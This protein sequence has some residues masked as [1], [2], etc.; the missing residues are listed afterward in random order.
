MPNRIF[1][2]DLNVPIIDWQMETAAGGIHENQVQAN[3]LP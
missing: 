1:A 2:R 3:A